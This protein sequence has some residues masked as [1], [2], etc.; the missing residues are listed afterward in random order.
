MNKFVMNVFF[1]D[2]I[3]LGSKSDY[4]ILIKIDLERVNAGQ[5]DVQTEVKF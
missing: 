4:S 2:R 3:L 1:F 5:E